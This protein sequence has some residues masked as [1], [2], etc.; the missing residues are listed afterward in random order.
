M[1]KRTGQVPSGVE[2]L[3]LIIG[4]APVLLLLDRPSFGAPSRCAWLRWAR[5]HR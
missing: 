2:T 3:S 1:N 5:D 4:M